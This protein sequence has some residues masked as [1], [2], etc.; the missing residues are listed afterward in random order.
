[1]E[2][3]SP[4]GRVDVVRER[5]DRLDVRPVPLHRDLELAFLALTL[6]IDDVLVDR[7]LRLVHMRD[8]VA[9]PA[10]VVELVDLPARPLV[11]DDDAQAAREKR[12][13]AQTL[14]KRRRVELGLVEDLRV[15]QERDRRPGLI[16][17]RHTDRLHVARGLAAREFLAVDLSVALHLGDEPLGERVDDR[18]SHTVEAAGHLVALAAELSAGV[19]L[20][21]DDRECGQPL[22]V[23]GVNR[24]AR[25]GVPDGDGVVGVDVDLDEIVAVGESLVDGVVDHLVDEVMKASRPGRPDVHAGSKADRLEAFEDSDVLCGVGCFGH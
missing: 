6:E 4:L 9:D 19:E 11:A 24:D 5:E 21:Q 16:L 18:D 7:V 10:L 2:V 13:L 17:G 22:L 12:R 1:L 20:G 15:G 3:R 14:R 23:D 25:A 8:E